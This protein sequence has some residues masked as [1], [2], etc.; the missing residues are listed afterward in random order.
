MWEWQQ[1]CLLWRAQ[2]LWCAP[3]SDFGELGRSD[4][5]RF[6]QIFFYSFPDIQP[7]CLK[8]DRW[9]LLLLPFSS[10][11]S[12]SPPEIS[13]A[14]ELAEKQSHQ[15]LDDIGYRGFKQIQGEYVHDLDH[16]WGGL[17]LLFHAGTNADWLDAALLLHRVGGSAS[18]I[19]R[20][21]KCGCQ[22]TLTTLSAVQVWPPQVS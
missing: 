13:S 9:E 18:I 11:S 4:D 16:H 10:M 22:R 15:I 17:L 3:T 6:K 14:E 1:T 5:I 19:R 2:G 12:R 7:G 20:L 8:L 21:C